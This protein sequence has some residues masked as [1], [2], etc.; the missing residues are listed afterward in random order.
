MPPP[1]SSLPLPLRSSSTPSSSLSLTTSSARVS[2]VAQ[3]MSKSRPPA[4]ALAIQGTTKKRYLLYYQT[5]RFTDFFIDWRRKPET[6]SLILLSE[7]GTIH[8]TDFTDC[9]HSA[10]PVD[11]SNIMLWRATILGPQGSPYYHSHRITSWQQKVRRRCL[12]S[13]HS[14]PSNI[15]L[16]S[17]KNP[18]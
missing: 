10:S 17:P 14:I 13:W 15:S 18:F 1:P 7:S 3:T 9:A 2:A 12:C 4:T 16:Q 5:V 11:D 8:M 6:Y